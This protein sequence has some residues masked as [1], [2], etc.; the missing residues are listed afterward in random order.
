MSGPGKP[1]LS[2][3]LPGWQAGGWCT[4]VVGTASACCICP[5]LKGRRTRAI[6]AAETEDQEQGTS[7]A[8]LRRSSRSRKSRKSGKSSKVLLAQR[9]WHGFTAAPG[10]GRAGGPRRG[11]HSGRMRRSP[12]FALQLFLA[13]GFLVLISWPQFPVLLLPLHK[14]L[15]IGF[16]AFGC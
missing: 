13:S 15:Y 6:T 8:A 12:H 14:S 2:R 9:A 3:L 10:E 5:A 16:G 1:H 4:P 11:W 7:F